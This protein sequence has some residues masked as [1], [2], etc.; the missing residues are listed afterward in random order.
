MSA[1]PLPVHHR[2]EC[3][4]GYTGDNCSENQDDCKDH[5]CQNGAQCVDE[6][7]SYACLCVEGYR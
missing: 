3:M 2:C 6:V 5:K 1:D 7:N 4:L